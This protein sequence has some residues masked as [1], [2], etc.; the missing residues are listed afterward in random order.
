VLKGVGS[1]CAF[2]SGDWFINT[3]GNPGLA[4][5]GMGD[6]L[7]G[8]IGALICQ[9]SSPHAALLSAV[10]IHGLAGDRLLDRLGAPVGITASE[11]ILATRSVINEIYASIER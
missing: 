1:V 9:G 10:H 8:L 6:V 2:N 3:S 5:A 7:A 4:A 11:V